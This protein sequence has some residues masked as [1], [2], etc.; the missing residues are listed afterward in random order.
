MKKSTRTKKRWIQSRTALAFLVG[1]VAGWLFFYQLQP[2][3]LG[4]RPRPVLERSAFMYFLFGSFWLVAVPMISI[5][6]A[7][8]EPESKSEAFKVAI[9][10]SGGWL[11]VIPL[12]DLWVTAPELWGVWGVGRFFYEMFLNSGAL[13]I[14]EMLLSLIASIIAAIV[15]PLCR[16][17]G[18]M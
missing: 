5:I 14:Y 10:T 11:I 7:A 13:I 8:F 3:F 2:A 12:I 15:S 18:R 4:W 17:L 6:V 1:L 16:F 9:V